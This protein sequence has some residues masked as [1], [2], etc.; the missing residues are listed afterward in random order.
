MPR[1]I[2]GNYTLP[3]GNPVG[4]ATVIDV[5]WANP[6]MADIAAQLNNVLTK[7]GVVGPAFPMKFPNGSQAGPAL[8]FISEP[9]LGFYRHSLRNLVVVADNVELARWTATG[10]SLAGTFAV[11][12][13]STFTGIPSGPTA[14][15]DTNTTQLATTAYVMGQGYLKSA[16]AAA[17]YAPLGGA[18]A[19]GTWGINISGSSA[20]STGNAA[21][22][23]KLATAR[24]INGV[25]F[26]GTANITV[27]AAA[28]TLT[29]ASLAAGVTGS[30]LTSVG[31]GCTDGSFELGYKVIPRTTD[32]TVNVAKRG[33]AMALS[34]GVTIPASTFSAG[35]AF[36]I[37]NDSAAAITLTQGASL[38]MRLGGTTTT[39]NRTL[40]ARGFVT[41][42]F[43]S[44]TECV[45]QGTGLT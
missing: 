2:S 21:T 7:D 26:D 39:G 31:P 37:Y 22:A 27:A 45:I 25:A 14:A 9:G 36:S 11:A 43:N 12:G 18:G 10:F 30:S 38:T 41:L 29:G 5:D 28:G 23:T 33:L 13:A 40:A 4:E 20:S 19:S 15:V 3:I 8:S 42:W 32:T 24:N 1:D 6:T 34:A 16:A 44:A 35:D 17:T